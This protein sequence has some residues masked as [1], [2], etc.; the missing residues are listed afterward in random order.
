MKNIWVFEGGGGG[1]GWWEEKEGIMSRWKWKANITH[2]I[3]I[4]KYIYIFFRQVPIIR[5]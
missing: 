3:K 1:G 2:R 4:T 5:E